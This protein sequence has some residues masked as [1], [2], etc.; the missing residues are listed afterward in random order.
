MKCPSCGAE[1]GN[2]K[3]CEFCGAQISLEMKKE[4]EQLNKQGCPKCGSSN[5]KFNRENQGEVH[6]KNAKRI[7]HRTVGFCQDCGHT[8]YPESA[9]NE[10]PKKNNMIWWV[11]GWI[12]FFPAPV[13]V[14]IW[15]K[16]N[17]WDIKVKIAVT[18]VFW[19]VFFA[20]GSANK[21]SE[22]ATTSTTIEQ[23][24]TQSEV[25]T[26]TNASEKAEN[27]ST[28]EET[29]EIK[30]EEVASIGNYSSY[31]DIY[32]EYKQK[33]I[34]ATPGLIEE[35]NNE[36]SSNNAG[37]EGLAEICNNKISKLAEISNEGVSE[38][39]D[40]MLKNGNGSY[41]DYEDWSGKLMQVYM[42][43]SGKITDA[44]MKSAQ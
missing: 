26:D 7:I 10:V 32:D 9:A 3:F 5:I 39:A 2:S 13:M 40:F 36:A 35:Y 30:S 29:T 21:S 38:M 42:D 6:G 34:D 41:S 23:T 19:I 22:N 28:T 18:V 37:L 1:V 17:T 25:K 16:K 15:R 4:Q 33:I 11:L 44:Y 20:I 31:E 43:E 8:W 27:K 12:F 24:E 14:L